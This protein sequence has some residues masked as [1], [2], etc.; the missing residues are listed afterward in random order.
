MSLKNITENL[1][2]TTI[3][4]S[5]CT[6][7]GEF[8]GDGKVKVNGKINGNVRVNGD[9]YVGETGVILGDV[10]ANNIHLFGTIEGNVKVK[11]FLR[12]G[13]NSKLK[14]D[15]LIKKIVVDEG[16]LFQGLCL[17][18]ENDKL[19]KMSDKINDLHIS[20]DDPKNFKRS[21]LIE[22]D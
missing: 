13:P 21:S 10:A 19:N 22:E 11:D 16:A 17:M 20:L 7:D 18:S 4:G 8:K 6:V 12:L 2:I 9:L 1:I 5:G 15:V 3:I 14:G